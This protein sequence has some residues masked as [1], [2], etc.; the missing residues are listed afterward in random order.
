MKN[1]RVVTTCALIMFVVLLFLFTMSEKLQLSP[2]TFAQGTFPLETHKAEGCT[3]YFELQLR[4]NEKELAVSSLQSPTVVD[5]FDFPVGATNGN[6]WLNNTGLNFLDRYDYGGSCGWTY[7]PGVDLNKDGTFVD[8]DQYE[9]VYA[10]AEGIVIKSAYY[11][12]STWGNVIL[13][14][15]TLPNG[16]KVWSQYGHLEDRWVGDGATVTKRQQ[17][18]RVGKGVG[19]P[20]HLHFEIRKVSL[21]ANAFPCGLSSTSV[22]NNYHNPIN[23]IN[24]NRTFQQTCS[25]PIGQGTSGL[26]LAAFQN[27][28]N[29]GG[30]QSTLGCAT[31][32][33]G[34][35]GFTSFAGTRSH[36]QTTTNGDI[37]YHISGSRIGQAFA[38]PN[39]F[40]N[41]WKGYEFNTNTN[42]LG[43]PIS[44][45]S[46]E[47]TS[48]QGTRH[49]FQSFEGG[50]LVQ[51]LSGS[52]SGQVY[53]V[54]GLI[55]H[56]WQ[57][58]GFAICPLGLPLSDESPAQRSGATGRNG[59]LNEFEGG[60]IYYRHGD[61]EAFMVHSAIKTKYVSLGGSASSLGFPTSNEFISN[62]R[63]RSNFEGGY[64][65]TLDG[66]TYQ[67]F[68][69]NQCNYSISPSSQSFS[70]TGGNGT[71]NVTTSA[72]CSRTGTSNV[73][74]IS[75]APSG[76]GS[77]SVIYS[78]T[79]NSGQARTG[80]ITIGE[81]NFT[82]NQSGG[83]STGCS[84]PATIGFGQT[85]NG[86]LQN[87]DCLKN[88][89]YYDAYAFNGAAGQRIYITL[90]STQFDTYLYLYRGSNISVNPWNW[91]DDD[92]GNSRNSR[93]PMN[94]GY[95]TL[96]SAGT[97]TILASS[98]LA[99]A[100][101]NYTLSLNSGVSIFGSTNIKTSYDF[102]SDGKTDFSLFRPSDG[103]WH[104]YSSDKTNE[105][106]STQFG[107]STDKITP[108][109]YDGDGR[110]D[111][112]VFRE[113]IWHLLRSTDGYASLQFGMSGDIPQPADYD[114]DGKAEVAVFRP[115]T[116]VWYWLNLQNNLF[117]IVQFGLNGDQPVTADYDGDN[118]A[119]IAI[120]RPSAGEW[121]ILRSNLGAI[122][123]Q[124]GK[125]TDKPVQGD[126]TGDRMADVAFFRPS[127]GEWF[128][129]R[130]ENSSYYSFPFGLNGDVPVPG[131]YDGDGKADAAVF[132]P[133]SSTWYVQGTTERTMIQN[134]GQAGD[135]PVP[136]AFVP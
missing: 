116:G 121:W 106:D 136:S 18:G 29:T 132:R 2:T 33:V 55:H 59:V 93:I 25:T 19:L 87:A 120:Y 58:S 98:Y 100:T 118:K 122:A 81:Q 47:A 84:S 38:V 13:I 64:I 91:N 124:F 50:S 65:T 110:T 39:P 66:V 72:G 67:A 28:Y 90:N 24:Q 34:L 78:V 52:R 71:I 76:T 115:S 97:Y 40:Y 79:S 99:G 125:S 53:E 44:N 8:Q 17:I 75:V 37:E 109:D 30:G 134:F 12:T 73:S 10:V 46:Q 16:T 15:H 32:S 48:C 4:D 43:Y 60:Q 119:D 92:S 51:H 20:A 61:A 123:F 127:T 35:D 26:E 21:T 23:F 111:I 131:D 41:K 108:A 105:F 11:G 101:G 112:A 103:V 107:I 27:A 62:G 74:W 42:F 31:A 96:P 22:T 83:V 85:I 77:G 7:H 63:P 82:V 14:E 129:L 135:N 89:R 54:H 113:G 1:I 56:R 69:Y 6:G 49:K 45:V 3:H 36:Y 126:Y 104:F 57:Q 102:N 80:I 133:S 117:N 70:L 86:T 95:I 94:S 5:G 130:S 88:S 114:G 68:S 128:I 9:P